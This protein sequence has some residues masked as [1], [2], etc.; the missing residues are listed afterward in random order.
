MPP[1]SR[2]VRTQLIVMIILGLVASVYAGIRF[3]RMDQALG[4]SGYRVVV[5]MTESGGIFAGAQVT[6]RGV[7][8]GRV[9][10]MRLVPGGV[11]IELTLESGAPDIPASSVAVVANRSAIGEQ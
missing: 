5:H 8:A 2:M 10:D 1:L 11:D 7:A 3:A 4:L 6:Y 9:S